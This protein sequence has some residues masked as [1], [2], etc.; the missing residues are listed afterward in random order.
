MLRADI[1][2]ILTIAAVFAAVE[3]LR[4]FTGKVNL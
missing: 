2:G 4:M 3:G 1:W